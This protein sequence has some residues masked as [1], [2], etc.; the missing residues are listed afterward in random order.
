MLWSRAL[1]NCVASNIWK[2]IRKVA[3]FA[4]KRPEG[5]FIHKHV[6]LKVTL[7]YAQ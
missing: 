3:K 4:Y 5:I 1:G 7:G 2:Y 6:D